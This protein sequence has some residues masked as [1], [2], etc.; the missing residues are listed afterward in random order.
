[1][2]EVGTNLL[3]EQ[4]N[5]S[6]PEL[7]V[8][9]ESVVEESAAVFAASADRSAGAQLAFARQQ[10]NMSVQQVADHLK[11]SPRQIAALEA[12]QFDALPKAVILRGF[13]RSYAKLLKI[14]AEPIV[15]L[16]PQDATPAGAQV[17][18][19]KPAMAT[20]FLESRLPL[21][22]RQDANNNKYILGA[23]LL[24]VLAIAFFAFQKL[25]HTDYL[26]NLL[27]ASSAP[28]TAGAEPA[29][30]AGDVVADPAPVVAADEQAAKAP[31]SLSAPAVQDAVASAPA[32][33]AEAAVV[34]KAEPEK[35]IAEPAAS[36]AVAAPVVV[37]AKPVVAAPASQTNVPAPS[38]A[39]A[40]AA[41]ATGVI[42]PANAM[43]LKFRQDS[44]VQVKRANGT[45]VTSHLARAGTEESFDVKEPLQVRLGNAGGVDGLLR[46]ASMDIQASKDSNVVNLN[47]K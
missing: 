24:A 4:L 36:L 39:V 31:V 18:A 2:S 30:T 13:V 16:L 45:V 12:N 11:L 21:M 33:T 43:K 28:P 19:L 1:M 44:W 42:D 46:G 34:T 41:G 8:A 26:K 15:A 7:D 9:P 29:A 25:E 40:A 6:E 20:P 35:K 3:P 5:T 22:G 23:G 17:T 10:K 47:V 37:P 32:K 14:D 27:P 38:P